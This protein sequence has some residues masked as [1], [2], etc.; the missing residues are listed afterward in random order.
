[1]SYNELINTYSKTGY[2][3]ELLSEEETIALIKKIQTGDEKSR[4]EFILRNV[5]LVNSIATAKVQNTGFKFGSLT[6]EDL[7]Q[8]GMI[9]LM[10]AVDKFDLTVGTKFSTYATWWIERAIEQLMQRE[11]NIVKIPEHT[12]D[13]VLV[14]TGMRDHLRTTLEREPSEDE[15]IRAMRGSI[16]T[17]KVRKALEIIEKS[18]VSPLDATLTTNKDGTLTTFGDML[19]DN[20]TE[21]P[22]VYAEKQNESEQ[23]MAAIE[24]LDEK[25]K[26]VILMRYGFGEFT[27][28]T[29]DK[30]GDELFQRGF[31]NNKGKKITKEGIR[32]IQIKAESD[33]RKILTGSG[34]KPW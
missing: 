21:S 25:S 3:N 15:I 6:I 5:K 12:L 29:L 7:I 23:L 10:K 26:L 9:G 22:E 13:L 17:K 16:G 2:S 14:V 11:G 34:I 4:D 33:L 27:E 20:D 28:M 30:I 31:V 8:E 24:Q 18:T 19:P 1:M 32:L